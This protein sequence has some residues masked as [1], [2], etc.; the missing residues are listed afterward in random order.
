MRNGHRGTRIRMKMNWNSP[1]AFCFY[2]FAAD[3]GGRVLQSVWR[4]I[5]SGKL[6]FQLKNK[7]GLRHG[8][9]GKRMR[10]KVNWNSPVLSVSTHL[11]PTKGGRVSF[12]RPSGE[13]GAVAP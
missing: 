10:T 6:T 7:M 12:W 3:H 13:V 9:K 5:C 2:I 1:F 4:P 8:H 11:Q